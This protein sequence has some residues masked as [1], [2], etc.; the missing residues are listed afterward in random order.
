MFAAI[1]QISREKIHFV[2]ELGEGAFGRV[3]LGLCEGLTVGDD[4][5]L[6]AVKTLKDKVR[7]PSIIVTMNPVAVTIGTNYCSN[8]HQMVTVFC[9]IIYYCNTIT[10]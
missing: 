4:M 7:L 8:C 1:R 9:I 5:S 10:Y 6:V 3:F 2:R